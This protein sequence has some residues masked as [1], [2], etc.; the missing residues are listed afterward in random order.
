M[1]RATHTL[2]KLAA[3]A[4]ALLSLCA[5]AAC[6]HTTAKDAPAP[7][8]ET[9]PT[10]QEEATNSRPLKLPLAS[11]RVLVR[12]KER[13]VMLYDGE[14]VVRVYR[15]VL[16]FAPE[17]D[18]VGQGDGR[19]PEG[20]FYVCVKNDKSRFHL[21]LGLSYPNEAAAE[22]G[23]RD[24]VITRRQYERIMRALR[25]KQRPPWDT[26]LGGEIMIH[27]GGTGGDWTLGCV[28]LENAHIEELFKVLPMGTPVRIEP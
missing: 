6:R 15:M 2:K 3:P 25:N 18:K 13:R 5:F 19:T 12:K 10:A 1:S 24:R 22:R 28:A 20:D 4:L 9:Q 17:G 7:R 8:A 26:P 23:L 16:G 21:S 27:G 14:A 11:P